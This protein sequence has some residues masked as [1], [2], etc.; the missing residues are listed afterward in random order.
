MPSRRCHC[1]KERRGFAST[2]RRSKI[3]NNSCDARWLLSH[4]SVRQHF[5]VDTLYL[6]DFVWCV[7][8]GW[9]GRLNL[10][11]VQRNEYHAQPTREQKH[12]RRAKPDGTMGCSDPEI[13]TILVS[14]SLDSNNACTSPLAFLFDV[15]LCPGRIV[16]NG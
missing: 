8:V 14:I 5:A 6:V 1:D 15:S 3:G 11:Q 10:N 9:C 7:W 13:Q 2:V 4:G 12:K 16:R